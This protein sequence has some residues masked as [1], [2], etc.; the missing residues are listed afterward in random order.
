MT[1]NNY[2]PIKQL[3]FIQNQCTN[4]L[5]TV[6]RLGGPL[7]TKTLSKNLTTFLKFFVALLFLVVLIC[8]ATIRASVVC[9]YCE[10][11]WFSLESIFILFIIMKWV[12]K[13]GMAMLYPI[14]S[15]CL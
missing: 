7:W 13:P 15:G 3:H 8:S 1:V 2:R 4:N 6:H 12:R 9:E 5:I 10:L 14:R 11:V